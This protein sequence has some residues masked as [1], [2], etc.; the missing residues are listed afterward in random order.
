MDWVTDIPTFLVPSIFQSITDL[1]TLHAAFLVCKRWWKSVNNEEMWEHVVKK[2]LIPNKRLTFLPRTLVPKERTWKWLCASSQYQPKTI[3]LESADDLLSGVLTTTL[4]DTTYHGD[5]LQGKKHGKGMMQF[6]GGVYE[7]DFVNDEKMGKGSYFWEHGDFYSGEFQDGECHGQGYYEFSDGSS[8]RGN[9][10]DGKRSGDGV[11]TWP[12]GDY[13]SGNFIDGFRCGQGTFFWLSF[14]RKY[15]GEF[16]DGECTGQGC[17]YFEDGDRYEGQF[18]LRQ[19]IELGKYWFANGDLALLNIENKT[20]V[21]YEAADLTT[22]VSEGQLEAGHFIHPD[23]NNPDHTKEYSLLHL[24]NGL[25][26][27]LHVKILP[28]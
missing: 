4:E 5:F 8:F 9:F 18:M 28:S 27:R 11:F 25:S 12:D 1:A 24:Q 23:P 13:Y 19:A 2:I 10:V 20:A 3:C 26:Y 6:P 16:N 14:L 7:G 21:F 15:Q 17:Y 22:P